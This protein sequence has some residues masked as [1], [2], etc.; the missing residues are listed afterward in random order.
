[1]E[2]AGQRRETPQKPSLRFLPQERSSRPLTSRAVPVAANARGMTTE[3]S[4]SCG[5]EVGEG[6][7]SGSLRLETIRP[8]ADG[9]PRG[10]SARRRT[11][12]GSSLHVH[13]PL[14]RLN[15]LLKREETRGVRWVSARVMVVSRAAQGDSPLPATPVKARN[16]FRVGRDPARAR[17]VDARGSAPWAPSSRI[18]AP[19]GPER[20]SESFRL[21]ETCVER[22]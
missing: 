7:L 17:R 15:G 22:R 13:E 8:F 5:A 19:S 18:L 14:G 20:C 2:W 4:L 12:M 10:G 21:M 9:G 1:M 11:H 6:G 3:V 16:I